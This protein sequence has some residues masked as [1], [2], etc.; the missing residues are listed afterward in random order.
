[1]LKQKNLLLKKD[2]DY[3]LILDACRYDFFKR[4]YQD[5]VHGNLLKVKSSGSNTREWLEKT[6]KDSFN[7]IVYVSGNPWIN[8]VGLK[9]E[10]DA[11]TH[12]YRVIDV[13]NFGWDENLE[14]VEPEVILNSL[15]KIE[16][17]Y[18]K[19]EKIIH[20]LQPHFPY[21]RAM[22]GNTSTSLDRILN[23]ISTGY[24]KK[25]VDTF[26]HRF[27]SFLRNFFALPSKSHWDV[28]CRQGRETL[29]D[30]YE[31]NLTRALGAIS[32][33]FSSLDGNV[34]ITSDHGE[35]LGEKFGNFPPHI[36]SEIQKSQEKFDRYDL[37]EFGNNKLVVGHPSE[38]DSE[39]LRSVPWLEI[40]SN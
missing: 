12:F 32:R 19:K 38:V 25:L 29:L 2:W 40:A 20:F 37:V 10:F 33:H 24:A 15:K 5:F 13:W 26:N 4:N 3:A 31:D 34:I 35:F 14:T 21:I 1:M 22:K 8:S 7:E 23:F 28:L 27:V 6:F 11:R 36:Q 30:L 9:E 18:P 17:N 16:K 39:I